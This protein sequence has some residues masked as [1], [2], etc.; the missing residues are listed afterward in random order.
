MY[1][2]TEY[3]KGEYKDLVQEKKDASRCVKCGKCEKACPQKL[4]IRNLLEEVKK[5]LS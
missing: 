2:D 1:N 3:Y 5:C 4:P